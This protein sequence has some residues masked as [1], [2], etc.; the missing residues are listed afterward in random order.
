MRPPA[1]TTRLE[2]P[3]VAGGIRSVNFFNGRLLSAEDLRS[4][5]EAR[6]AALQRLGL[7]VGEG[8]LYG[9]EVVPMAAGSP[10]DQPVVTVRGGAAINGDGV[11]LSLPV[12]V[13]L[14]LV[15]DPTDSAAATGDLFADCAP[16]Q[17]GTFTTGAGLYLL[18]MRP[19]Q[20]DQG[21]A[22]VSGLGNVSAAC[23]TRWSVE[24][25]AFRL[26]QVGL[27]QADLQ[28]LPQLRNVV[29][30]RAYGTGD[31]RRDGFLATPFGQPVG[32][33]GLLDDLRLTILRSEEVPLALVLWTAEDGILFVDLWSVRRRATRPPAD[34]RFPTLLGDRVLAEAEARLLQFEQQ[35]EEAVLS[36]VPLDE[37]AASTLFAFLPP[38]GLLPVRGAGSP[39]G[40]DVVTFFT[41]QAAPQVP[42][43]DA[44]L[45][46]GLVHESL[47]HEPI[48]VDG[49]ELIQ[50]YTVNEN[51]QA[52]AQ[53]LTDQLVVVFAKATLPYR[54]VAR[55]GVDTFRS[56]RFAPAVT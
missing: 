6:R 33:Y 37:A 53:G 48:A 29:A 20:V 52:V 19:G 50:L 55:Y 38:I 54:G 21:R 9:L 16:L 30:H 56:S 12:E 10:P 41:P 18:T 13:H 3:V 44:A 14:S 2:E 8:V 42:T 23:N 46:R 39:R 31:A 49:A 17:A 11:L 24:G 22:P 27:T 28:T 15:R 4:E 51:R 40:F 25:V 1:H 7:G 5:Q 34:A 36:G 32:G 45:V 47:Y 35:A 43:T 26:I